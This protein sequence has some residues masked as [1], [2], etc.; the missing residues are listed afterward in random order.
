VTEA[1]FTPC[2]NHISSKKN[3]SGGRSSQLLSSS[4]RKYDPSSYKIFL[5]L[6]QPKLETF[7]LIQLIYSQNIIGEILVTKNDPQKCNGTYLGVTSIQRPLPAQDS[8]RNLG[9]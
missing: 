7:E 3:S 9:P 6:L 4:I 5:L 8:R 1:F 2:A